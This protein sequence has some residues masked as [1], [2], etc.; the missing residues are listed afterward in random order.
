M[1]MPNLSACAL[2]SGE[3][4]FFIFHIAMEPIIETNPRITKIIVKVSTV[5]ISQSTIG[6]QIK[7]FLNLERD[8]FQILTSVHFFIGETSSASAGGVFLSRSD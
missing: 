2:S 1:K 8:R 7:K 3:S 5:N 4:P 6:C